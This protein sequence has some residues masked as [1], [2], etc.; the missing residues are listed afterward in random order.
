MPPLPVSTLFYGPVKRLRSDPHVGQPS[1]LTS[2]LRRVFSC[3][4]DGGIS[5]SEA[6]LLSTHGS[7]LLLF[8]SFLK[9]L[10][11]LLPPNL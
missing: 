2:S 5:A 7:F 10:C 6:D 9:T 3:D 11:L 1:L 8:F 4:F